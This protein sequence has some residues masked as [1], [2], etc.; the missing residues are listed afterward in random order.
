MDW[1]YSSFRRHV[2]AGI[3]PANWGENEKELDRS[4]RSNAQTVCYFINSFYRPLHM[5]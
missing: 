4:S 3:Y 5:R 1:P 2:Q